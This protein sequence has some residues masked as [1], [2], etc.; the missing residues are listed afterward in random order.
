MTAPPVAAVDTHF[1][2]DLIVQDK[3]IS[4]DPPDPSVGDTVTF[5]VTVMNQGEGDAG[6]SILRYI[7]TRDAE[8]ILVGEVGVPSIPKGGSESVSLEWIADAG[9]HSFTFERMR[10]TRCMRPPTQTTTGST[11]LQRHLARGPRRRVDRLSPDTPVMGETVTFSA[12]VRNQGEGRAGA[13][14]VEL[15]VDEV[16]VG[17]SE[18]P[19]ILPGESET[20]SSKW[21]A[22]A[23]P[24]TLR[25]LADSGLA[26][27]E[28]D[29][30]NNELTMAYEA[31]I[32]ADWSWKASPGSLKI[33]RWEM[34][35][36]SS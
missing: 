18:I 23:G 15:Y 29:D 36:R 10:L 2:A 7:V 9:V 5:T 8:T 26:I 20:G 22:E 16:I 25:A 27:S 35:S 3:D 4:F 17:V 13:T 31:T 14:T 19:S 11:A 28:N 32:F 6:L 34:K 21:D 30:G 1:L 33:H 24:H 12:T